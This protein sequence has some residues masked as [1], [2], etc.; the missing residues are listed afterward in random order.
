MTTKSIMS[1]KRTG[2]CDVNIEALHPRLTTVGQEQNNS[3]RVSFIF[4][5]TH[6]NN[7]SLSEY[8]IP[9]LHSITAINNLLEP[10]F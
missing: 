8:I 2:L 3:I 1:K 4:I 9:S 7:G 10:Y 6:K 5:Y